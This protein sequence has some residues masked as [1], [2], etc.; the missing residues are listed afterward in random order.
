MAFLLIESSRVQRGDLH[1]HHKG[2]I[3]VQSVNEH[4]VEGYLSGLN[5]HRKAR[6]F[7]ENNWELMLIVMHRFTAFLS[8]SLN[9]ISINRFWES[10][11]I[12]R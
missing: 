2:K 9:L 12:P 5:I 4:R 7:L 3:S 11:G 6:I 10:A 1:F 8:T